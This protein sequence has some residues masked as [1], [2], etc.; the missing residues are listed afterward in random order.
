MQFSLC[1]LLL[2]E[3]SRWLPWHSVNPVDGKRPLLETATKQ[4]LVT[5]VTDWE[6]L[7]APIMRRYH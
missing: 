5:T 6:G 7:K 1:E 3:A 4:R 2:L